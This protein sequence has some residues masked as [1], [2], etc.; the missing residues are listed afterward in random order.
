MWYKRAPHSLQLLKESSKVTVLDPNALLNG[1]LTNFHVLCTGARPS[2]VRA[3][4]DFVAQS[5]AELS[6]K[7]GDLIHL[8]DCDHQ[9]SMK[10]MPLFLSH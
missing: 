9:V 2:R 8:L 4:Y 5:E 6:F 7:E 1:R 3:L 10:E